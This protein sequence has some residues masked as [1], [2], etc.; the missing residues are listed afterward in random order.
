MLV[1]LIPRRLALLTHHLVDLRQ[2]IA[3][4]V[5]L[6]WAMLV[7]LAPPL[8]TNIHMLVTLMGQP[9]QPLLPP[10]AVLLPPTEQLGLTSNEEQ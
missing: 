5:F 10:L 1:T 8:E 7:E 2:G 3:L 4:G 6:L 9:R